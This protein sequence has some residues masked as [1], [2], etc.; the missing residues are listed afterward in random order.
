MTFPQINPEQIM[1]IRNWPRLKETITEL[2]GQE[3]SWSAIENRLEHLR[4]APGE[5]MMSYTQ[6]AK[7]LY[8]DYLALYGINQS[9]VVKQKTAREVAKQFIKNAASKKMREVLLA[10]GLNHDLS[11]I[12]KVALEQEV[13]Q[14]MDEP[15]L[16]VICSYCN[17]RGHRRR[18]CIV[19]DRAIRESN[20]LSNDPNIQCTKCDAIGHSAYVCR[21]VPQVQLEQQRQNQ[22]ANRSSGSGNQDRSNQNQNNRSNRND[23]NDRN[24]RNDRNNQSERNDR[25]ENNRNN[26]NE[27]RD[28][29]NDQ[30]NNGQNGQNDRNDRG[31]RRNRND[32][33]D[34]NERNDRTDRSDRGNRND[35]G[36]NRDNRTNR[37]SNQ[38]HDSHFGQQNWIPPFAYAPYPTISQSMNNLQRTQFAPQQQRPVAN[39]F[40]QR[41]NQYVS[42]PNLAQMTNQSQ[43]STQQR[44]APPAQQGQAP[45]NRMARTVQVDESFEPMAHSTDYPENYEG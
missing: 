9:N 29:R 43:G 28:G 36:S 35:E 44:A 37:S 40:P 17:K 13:L 20:S 24:E 32:R 1:A 22:N 5:S 42:M 39:N 25:N 41:D 45:Q 18:D 21:V 10:H 6:K 7:T 2:T 3:N 30:T 8:N 11:T 31:N 26:R 4:Q 27:N 14:L 16:E 33:G 23:R 38:T 34:R 15:D 19:R 12:T